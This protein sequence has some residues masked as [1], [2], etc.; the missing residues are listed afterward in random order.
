MTERMRALTEL[1]KLVAMVVAMDRARKAI[2]DATF[3]IAYLWLS[4]PGRYGNRSVA[5]S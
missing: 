5:E 2:P 3:G 4:R 1:A